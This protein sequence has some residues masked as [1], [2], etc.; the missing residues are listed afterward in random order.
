MHKLTLT[1]VDWHFPDDFPFYPFFK[2]D[3]KGNIYY[4]R[5]GTNWVYGPELAAAFACY[6]DIEKYV[7]LRV[8]HEFM[9]GSDERPF[10]FVHDVYALRA[11]LK[12]AGNPD[13][14]ELKLFVN[15]LYGKTVQSLG[16]NPKTG[17]LPPYFNTFYGGLTT[18]GVRAKV[19]RAAME[20][21][22]DIICFATDGIYSTA[23]LSVPIS[24]T[25]GDWSYEELAGL[26]IVQS[27]VYWA[28]KPNGEVRQ[29]YR[30]FDK[31][32]LTEERV[33]AAWREGADAL[34]VECTRFVTLGSALAGGERLEKWRTWDTM[35]RKL[36]LYAT[37]KREDYPDIDACPA[38]RLIATRAGHSKMGEQWSYPMVYPWDEE[39]RAGADTERF[40]QEEYTREIDEDMI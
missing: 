34:P 7:G 23:P 32:N 6:P 30:G 40:L 4:P 36:D 3:I 17:R 13:E 29:F 5:A 1:L 18:S 11:A 10:A 28:H 26:T 22:Y 14:K 16:Y 21:P 39:Y 25:L 37:G 20:R 12:A 24:E 27:G 31:E 33:L 8:Q 9:P 35:E 2:R 38:D 15:S 19:Y